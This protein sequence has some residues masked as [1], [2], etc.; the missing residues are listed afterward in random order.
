ML[1]F[2]YFFKRRY[3]RITGVHVYTVNMQ[4][5]E[6]YDIWSPNLKAKNK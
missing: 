2:N 3:I 4:K 1:T 5:K 6:D